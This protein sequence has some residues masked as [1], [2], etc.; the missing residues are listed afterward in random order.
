MLRFRVEKELGWRRHR[1]RNKCRFRG[2]ET[3]S[4]RSS[5]GRDCKEE[6]GMSTDGLKEGQGW[7]QLEREGVR[8]GDPM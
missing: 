8:E 4:S 7:K 3:E 6:W 5:K 2:L 1:H